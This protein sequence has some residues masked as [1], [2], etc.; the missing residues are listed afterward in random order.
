M[1]ADPLPDICATLIQE[2]ILIAGFEMWRNYGKQFQKLL[3][4]IYQPYMAKLNTVSINLILHFY[5]LSIF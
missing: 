1:Y 4:T 5:L 2:F 3:F